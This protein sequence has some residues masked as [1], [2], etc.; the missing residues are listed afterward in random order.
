M[1]L[2]IFYKKIVPNFL[3]ILQRHDRRK[4]LYNMENYPNESELKRNYKMWCISF[5]RN[6]FTE[7]EFLKRIL[8]Y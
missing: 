4:T 1:K 2:N 5:T 7:Q 8:K 6:D 3:L